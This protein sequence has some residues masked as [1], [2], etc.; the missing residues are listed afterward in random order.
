MKE[1][2]GWEKRQVESKNNV[3]SKFASSA[4]QCQFCCL[5]NIPEVWE[6][7]RAGQV[8]PEHQ[9]ISGCLSTSFILGHQKSRNHLKNIKKL[10]LNTH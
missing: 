5:K 1:A 4:L 10:S 9:V 7:D 3:S 8:T 6:G 2:Q